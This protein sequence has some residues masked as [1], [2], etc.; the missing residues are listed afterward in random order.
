VGPRATFH[1]IKGQPIAART[2][3]DS[4]RGR[5]SPLTFGVASAPVMA[6]MAGAQKASSDP[7]SV[8]SSAAAPSSLPKF[9]ARSAN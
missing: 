6:M 5:A 1:E 2:A 3:K 4:L 8:I 7:I 9:D